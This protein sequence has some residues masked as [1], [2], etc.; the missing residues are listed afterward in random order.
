M[1]FNPETDSSPLLSF[2]SVPKN[3]RT[4]TDGIDARITP[5]VN[6]EDADDVDDNSNIVKIIN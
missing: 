1:I 3:Y 2:N 4:S 6:E 5:T